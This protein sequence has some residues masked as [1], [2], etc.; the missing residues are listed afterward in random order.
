[1]SSQKILTVFLV[2]SPHIQMQV[3]TPCMITSIQLGGLCQPGTGIFSQR[4]KEESINAESSYL[5]IA[6]VSKGIHS[7]RGVLETDGAAQHDETQ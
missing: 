3:P 7:I 6:N 4:V 2:A 1:M 5:L